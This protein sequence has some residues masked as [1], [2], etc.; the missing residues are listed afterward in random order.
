MNY[1]AFGLFIIRFWLGFVFIMHGAQKVFGLFEGPGLAGFAAAVTEMGFP[2][3]MGYFAAFFEFIGGGLLLLGILPEIGALL[4]I[5]VMLVAIFKVHF[6]AGFFGQNG[7]F[8]YP[9][10]LLILAVVIIISG[11]GKFTLFDYFKNWR[12]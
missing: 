5:P 8:E 2:G 12:E 1:Q 9:L 3:W 6:A 11:G 7:G 4:T 10:N